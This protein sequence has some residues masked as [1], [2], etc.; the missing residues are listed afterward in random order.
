MEGPGHYLGHQQTLSLMQ[1]EYVYPY[2]GDR[3][4]PKQWEELGRPD[5]LD[6]A[7]DRKNEI[8]EA[9]KTPLFEPS[10]DKAIRERFNIHI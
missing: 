1:T 10:L 4:S 5:L 6:R 3:F 9:S 8:L 2:T 7:I